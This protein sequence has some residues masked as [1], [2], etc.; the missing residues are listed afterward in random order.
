MTWAYSDDPSSS[1]KDAVR[2]MV[3]DTNQA[4]QQVTD[5]EINFFLETKGLSVGWAAVAIA[6]HL[7]A[8]Y[9]RAV[10]KA[11]GTLRLSYSQ[12]RNAYRALAAD[13]ANEAG[14]RTVVPE[15]F[16]GGA[17]EPPAFTRRGW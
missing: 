13:L 7:A 9:A 15:V 2:F 12:R 6:R 1:D 8:K 14:K 3:G 4:D 17:D 5:E 10:D 16:V 11:V